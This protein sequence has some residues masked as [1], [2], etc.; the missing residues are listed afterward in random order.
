MRFIAF[1]VCTIWNFLPA[2]LR[3]YCFTC[4]YPN[5]GG[6][7][8]VWICE[9]LYCTYFCISQPLAFPLVTLSGMPLHLTAVWV[10]YC[11]FTS[12]PCSRSRFSS[13]VQSTK[14]AE[15][16]NGAIHATTRAE[17]PRLAFS[18]G[19]DMSIHKFCVLLYMTIIFPHR[20][21]IDSMSAIVQ[22]H[23]QECKKCIVS[24]GNHGEVCIFHLRLLPW[25][26]I[27]L[28]ANLV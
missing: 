7:H 9:I 16:D 19:W 18:Q 13:I 28:V 25:K 15:S 8:Q 20:N 24:H 3:K 1:S 21:S 17:I 4:T 2:P 23:T 26:L 10:V 22:N 5:M 27:Q 11:A 14:I 6:S 12:C